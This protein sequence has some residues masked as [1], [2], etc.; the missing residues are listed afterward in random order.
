MTEVT[1]RIEHTNDGNKV[2]IL[3]NGAVLGADYYHKDVDDGVMIA[4]S[5]QDWYNVNLNEIM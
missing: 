2:T 5:V 1:F 4:C 3:E